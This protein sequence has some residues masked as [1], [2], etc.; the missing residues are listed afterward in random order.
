MKP[1]Y[2]IPLFA[3][4][5][6]SLGGAVFIGSETSSRQYDAA[7]TNPQNRFI[8]ASCHLGSAD[9]TDPETIGAIADIMSRFEIVAL[10]YAQDANAVFAV[11]E[12]VAEL[13]RYGLPYEYLLDPMAGADQTRY[14]FVYRAD[15]IL[16]V[17]WYSYHDSSTDDFHREPLIAKFS[18]DYG[19]FDFILVNYSVEADSGTEETDL[20]QN[21]VTDVKERY[22]NE[23]DIIILCS[24]KT[25][26]NPDYSDPFQSLDQK[27][28]IPL[29]NTA[30]A[31]D[32]GADDP[33][34]PQIIIADS[35]EE[36]L[37]ED[38]GV[39]AID[40]ESGTE[41]DAGTLI[42]TSSAGFSTIIIVND[43]P[44]EK[45]WEEGSSSKAFCFF[46]TSS[47]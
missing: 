46:G 39:L 8:I 11:E 47:N 21:V 26:H 5:F 44:Q 19:K 41:P 30:T 22:P 28:Y 42:S 25:Y 7:I 35:S 31:H 4:L 14:A 32:D 6:Y 27:N 13:N 40:S 37:W 17:E 33:F 36:M 1:E 24:A 38:A 9:L 16:P 10:Q 29:L 18:A 2:K 12:L 23:T 45:Y 15:I 20:L 3:V 43:A 34:Y